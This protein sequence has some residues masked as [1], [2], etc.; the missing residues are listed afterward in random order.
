[1]IFQFLENCDTPKAHEILMTNYGKKV[2]RMQ[3][4]ASLLAK[5][6]R[7]SNAHLAPV[8]GIS[9][10]INSM[11]VDSMNEMPQKDSHRLKAER[12][13]LMKIRNPI[14]AQNQTEHF[15][16]PEDALQQQRGLATGRGLKRRKSSVSNE[17]PTSAL[18]KCMRS[19]SPTMQKEM[20]AVA[21]TLLKPTISDNVFKVP[22]HARSVSNEHS[23]LRSTSTMPDSDSYSLSNREYVT[24]LSVNSP[25][26]KLSLPSYGLLRLPENAFII[27]TSSLRSA[28]QDSSQDGLLKRTVSQLSNGSEFHDDV[29]PIKIKKTQNK[30]SWESVKLYHA[31]SKTFSIQNGSHKKLP[32]RVK[33]QGQG[34]SVSPG[35]DFRM[36]PNEARTFEVKFCPTSIGASRGQ[37]IFEL[38]TNNKCMKSI[39]LFAYG[40]HTAIRIEGVL[41]GPVGP[42]FITMGST[43]NLTKVMEQQLTL[44]N[45]GTLTGFASLV[46]EKT[47]W[48]DFSL[49]ESVTI[50]PSHARLAPNESVE[51]NIRFK[52]S[53]EE[54]RKILTLNKEITIVGEICLISGDEPTRLRLLNNRDI[55]PGHFLRFLPKNMTHEVEIKRELVLFNESLDRVK[56]A[57]IMEQIKTHE[58]ALTVNRNLDQTHIIASELSMSDDTTMSFETFCETN[59]NQTN[60]VEGD[61]T[62]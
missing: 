20:Q 23:V 32:L 21:A 34:F 50:H 19:K 53:K 9:E 60:L 56:I 13:H 1:M 22:H 16:A 30:L 45:N 42:F 31:V 14:S 59:Y 15:L 10:L 37:L 52:A 33:I 39:P 2:N 3:D 57:S 44:K 4:D 40:G 35:D 24:A 43:E 36:I 12:E 28:L 61:D 18:D 11:H 8:S 29:L 6:S 7:V 51:V 54:I 48:S 27:P 46:F 47:K 25:I 26:E 58:V 5:P 49:S 41:R 55:V 38:A 17:T 62:E